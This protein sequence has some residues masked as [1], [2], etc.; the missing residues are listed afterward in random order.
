[1][2]I[3]K[4]ADASLAFRANQSRPC[5]Q[6]AQFEALPQPLCAALGLPFPSD[7]L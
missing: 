5:T 7:W 4:V 2:G 6:E 1:M 3:W